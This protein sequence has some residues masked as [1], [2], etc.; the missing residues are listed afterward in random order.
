MAATTG[1]VRSFQEERQGN[2]GSEGEEVPGGFTTP[3]FLVLYRFFFGLQVF[4]DYLAH[5]ILGCSARSH[6]VRTAR[7]FIRRI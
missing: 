4:F 5:L 7:Q 1:L 3:P 6:P 2:R